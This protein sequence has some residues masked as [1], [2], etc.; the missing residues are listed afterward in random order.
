MDRWTG[1]PV[2]NVAICCY[3]D[4]MRSHP[5]EVWPVSDLARRRTEIVEE[6]TH[7]VA[8]IH[9]TD[10]TLLAFT[11]ASRFERLDIAE[12]HQRLLSAA[13]TALVDENARPAALGEVAFLTGW[14]HPRRR[15][16]AEDLN[17]VIAHASATGVHEEVDAFLRMS[18]PRPHVGVVDP[19]RIR[20]ALR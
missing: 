19:E 13:V 20:A 8:M 4:F 18:A 9:A 12:R 2:N 3:I 1:G 10:G 15:Q 5:R 17:D 14:T 16:F 6:A 11:K 7:G